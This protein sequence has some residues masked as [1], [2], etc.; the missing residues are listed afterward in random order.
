MLSLFDAVGQ[1]LWR[2]WPAALT[3]NEAAASGM[4]LVFKHI[5]SV[6]HPETARPNAAHTFTIRNIIFLNRS[7]DWETIATSST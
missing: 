6:L 7:G 2:A 4:T 1:R 3:L 5:I